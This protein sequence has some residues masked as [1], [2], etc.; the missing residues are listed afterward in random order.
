MPDKDEGIILNDVSVKGEGVTVAI[1]DGGIDTSHSVFSEKYTNHE[2]SG[3][4]FVPEFDAQGQPT[5]KVISTK[6]RGTRRSRDQCDWHGTAVAATVAGYAFKD[7][8]SGIA[9]KAKLYICRVFHK[10]TMHNLQKALKHLLRK[11][12]VD[13][14]CFPISAEDHCTDEIRQ[15]LTNLSKKAVLVASAGNYGRFQ[16]C[17]KFPARHE[18]VLSVGA[19]TCGGNKSDMNACIG[20]QVYAP[21]ERIVLP[22]IDIENSEA[23]KRDSGTSFAAPMIAGFIA[24]LIQCAKDTPRSTDNV[25]RMYHDMSFLT[26]VFANST[27]CN[28]QLHLLHAGKFLSDLVKRRRTENSI[29][30]LIKQFNI[31]F[32]P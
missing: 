14:V 1:V 13:V 7:V 32:I 5:E 8:S 27:A 26:H 30:E 31:K 21:G 17:A 18:R 15:L 12:D 9:P 2:I 23:T 20:I 29:V 25:V 19:L 24:L 4:N 6:W 16:R 10:G 28:E 22:D 11:D 3:Y